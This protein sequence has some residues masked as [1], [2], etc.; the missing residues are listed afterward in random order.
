MI[1]IKL[2]AS[3]DL[4]HFLCC[5]KTQ[6]MTRIGRRG[7]NS[8]MEHHRRSSKERETRLD[9]REKTRLKVLQEIV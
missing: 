8:V 2:L 1:N 3:N 9:R 6:S 4:N 5:N 7:T